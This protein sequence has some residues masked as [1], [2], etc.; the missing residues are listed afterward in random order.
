M[1]EYDV[2]E[3]EIWTFAAVIEEGPHHLQNDK[4]S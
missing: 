4:F 2:E 1:D 3:S